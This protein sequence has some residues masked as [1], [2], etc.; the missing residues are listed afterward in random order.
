[1]RRWATKLAGAAVVT[2][3]ATAAI[4]TGAWA[5]APRFAAGQYTGRVSQVIPKP[6]SGLIGF[7]IRGGVLTGLHFK[8]EMVCGRLLLAQVASPP[9]RLRVRV[10]HDGAFSYAGRAGG[11]LVRLHGIVRGRS[12]TGTFFESFHTTPTYGCTM[13]APAPFGAA[14]GPA[15]A[16]GGGSGT[17]IGVGGTLPVG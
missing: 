12:A 4:A 8:V 2:L 7:T 11:A 15:T 9:S 17:G 3:A 10:R 1:M 13:F 16:P 5:R 6:F 14:A